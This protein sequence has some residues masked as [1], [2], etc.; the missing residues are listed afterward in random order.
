MRFQVAEKD[1]K[2]GNN[3]NGTKSSNRFVAVCPLTGV[4]LNGAT[5]AYLI[6]RSKKTKKNDTSA[7]AASA[8]ATAG[9]DDESPNVLSER[10][11]REVGAE[12][13][14]KSTVHSMRKVL[15]HLPPQLRAV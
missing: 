15:S 4:E 7:T 14:R 6:V 13:F 5:P 8:A 2:V 11:I 9:A 3:G 10:A 12:S 1:D